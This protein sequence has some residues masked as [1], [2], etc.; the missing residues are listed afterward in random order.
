MRRA[1]GNSWASCVS[2]ADCRQT[3]R[4]SK[5]PTPTKLQ[6]LRSYR[7][8][9]PEDH[10]SIMTELPG[11]SPTRNHTSRATSRASSVALLQLSESLR[12]TLKKSYRQAGPQSATRETIHQRAC[13]RHDYRATTRARASGRTFDLVGTPPGDGKLIRRSGPGRVGLGSRLSM[14]TLPCHDRLRVPGRVLE[15]RR[16]RGG[17]HG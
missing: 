15:T 6:L 12:R 5:S 16:V 13:G 8:P 17:L 7:R 3:R 9:I 2:S 1:D 11:L 10:L 14:V 4:F